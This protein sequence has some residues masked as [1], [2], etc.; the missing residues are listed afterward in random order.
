MR[1]NRSIQIWPCRGQIGFHLA[2]FQRQ[3]KK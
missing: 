1:E 2:A 3:M